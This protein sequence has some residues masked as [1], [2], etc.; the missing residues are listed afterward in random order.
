MT[1]DVNANDVK[2]F[3]T[4]TLESGTFNFTF[5]NLIRKEFRIRQGSTITFTGDPLNLIIDASA[6]YT[7]TASLRDLFG[8][9]FSSVATNRTSVPVNCIIYLRENIL[10]PL[11]SFGLEL[12]QSD[13]SIN[14]Q[15]KGII[16]TDEMM[17]RQIMYLLIFNRFYTP[18]YL[19][20]ETRPGLSETYSLLSSTVTGQINNWLRRLTNNFTLGFNIR[21]DGFDSSSSQEYETQFQYVH[22]NRLIINGNFGY[23]YNDISNQ[24]VFGN[25]DVE[26]LLTPSGMFR[27]K[28]YTHMVDKYSLRTANTVQ[29]VGLMF[30]YDF[31]GSDGKSSKAG[32]AK[33]NVKSRRSKRTDEAEAGEQGAD[34]QENTK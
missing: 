1:Y 2:L 25:L 24:P 7:T 11:I 12:P 26:Y 23:R 18:E 16:N 19:Q 22:N 34:N 28:A 4:Y 9:D 27:A 5:E 17:M 10:N 13:E 21:T 33:R 32:K 8:T 20:T 15:V 3:G 31:N 6:V 30:K 14:S 29:G